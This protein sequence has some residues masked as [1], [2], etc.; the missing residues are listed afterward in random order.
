[1][2]Q[3]PRARNPIIMVMPGAYRLAIRASNNVTSDRGCDP[4]TL[5]EH[6]EWTTVQIELKPNDRITVHFNGVNVCQKRLWG[7]PWG[8]ALDSMA[9]FVYLALD[10]YIADAEVRSVI[11]EKR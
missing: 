2:G 11:Y 3:G 4:V 9:A 5:L 7:D 1:V 8:Q 10:E 6:N